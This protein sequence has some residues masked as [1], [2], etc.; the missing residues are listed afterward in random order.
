M[1]ILHAL[2]TFVLTDAQAATIRTVYEQGGEDC[3]VTSAPF[4]DQLAD[5][6]DDSIPVVD[7]RRPQ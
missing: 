3:P 1:G 5:A 6:L 2:A 4:C 7:L